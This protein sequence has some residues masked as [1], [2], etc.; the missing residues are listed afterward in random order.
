[1][2]ENQNEKSCFDQKCVLV[3]LNNQIL[4]KRSNQT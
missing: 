2:K 4:V 3:G 1:M